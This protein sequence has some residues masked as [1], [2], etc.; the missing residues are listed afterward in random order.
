MHF[1][2]GIVSLLQVAVLPGLLL[3]PRAPA[4]PPLARGIRVFVTSLLVNYVLVALLTACHQ[5][6]QHSWVAIVGIELLLLAW[7]RLRR[8]PPAGSASPR[9]LE[10]REPLSP[11]AVAA[12]TLSLVL[13]GFHGWQWIGQLGRVFADF[14][15][16][17]SWNRWALAWASNRWPAQTWNYPQLLPAN[18]SV[19]YVL[20]GARE[21]E[22]FARFLMGA[23]PALVLLALL[24]L[25]LRLRQPALAVSV[26]VALLLMIRLYPGARFDGMADLPAAA[27]GFAGIHCLLAARDSP[28]PAWWMTGAGLAL[29]AACVTKQAGL[30]LLAL[31]AVW[32]ATDPLL[33]RAARASGNAGR[34]ALLV[35]AAC[36]AH[37][38]LL[39]LA[40]GAGNTIAV[41]TT[42]HEGRDL[43][44]RVAHGLS[45]LA[46]ALRPP[47][48]PAT[49][50]ALLLASFARSPGARLV[51]N[52]V[53]PCLAVWLVSFS[54]DIRNLAGAV[55]PAALAAGFGAARI[56]AWGC[57]LSRRCA[58]RLP[59][60]PRRGAALALLA[61]VAIVGAGLLVPDESLSALHRAARRRAGDYAFNKTVA[62][63]A[64]EGGSILTACLEI[65]IQ[66][67]LDRRTTFDAQ[68]LADDPGLETR[69]RTHRWI[70]IEE[71]SS[72]QA[73]AVRARLVREG[74]LRELARSRNF[75]LC[76]SIGAQPQG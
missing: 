29:G 48:L 28:Q 16:I 45:L 21:G 4:G 52:F 15:A 3:T 37:W 71:N 57:A 23:F 50:A 62:E 2:L 30:L 41:T 61:A 17:A 51:L 54:Y 11:S 44:E 49:L 69:L 42:V 39:R 26:G 18:W 38:Y 8:N 5:H 47:L 68:P 73:E 59:S 34:L 60:G 7:I 70:I 43:A 27:L 25:Q 75:I 22:F 67:G 20:T 46:F 32:I 76:E 35:A 74:R 53:A 12:A 56:F 1:A 33:R 31:A 6:R 13:L 55:P 66:P 64:R 9:T 40:A 65:T 14:D 36:A 24:D 10:P 72:P 19:A 58:A 63:R